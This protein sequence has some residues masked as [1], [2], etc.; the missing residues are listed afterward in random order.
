MAA[1]SVCCLGLSPARQQADMTPLEDHAQD[2][3][4]Q[5]RVTEAELASWREATTLAG[6]LLSQYVRLAV[7]GRAKLDR[8]LRGE[9]ERRREEER[10]RRVAAQTLSGTEW[11]LCE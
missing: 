4:C 6:V 1:S 5:I 7:A 2:R 3:G 9:A 10:M 11:E 8:V